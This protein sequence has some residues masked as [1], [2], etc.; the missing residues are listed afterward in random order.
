VNS[1]LEVRRMRAEGREVAGT[2]IAWPG[3]PSRV[4]SSSTVETVEMDHEAQEDG[5]HGD[6]GKAE[7]QQQQQ[8]QES[9]LS[10]QALN[11]QDQGQKL[12]PF[13]Q[14]PA[15]SGSASPLYDHQQKHGSAQQIS[16]QQYDFSQHQQG[17]EQQQQ[18]QQDQSQA[19]SLDGTNA[20]HWNMLP[21]YSAAVRSLNMS[22]PNGFDA[23]PFFKYMA[24]AGL[25][26]PSKFAENSNQAL[27]ALQLQF[28]SLKAQ[29]QLHQ[30]ALKLQQLQ[31]HGDEDYSE[32]KTKVTKKRAKRADPDGKGGSV[33][34]RKKSDSCT[35]KHRGVTW[36]R[37]DKRW[38]ARAWIQGKINN[39]GSYPT[40][41]EA[42]IVVDEKYIEI[43]GPEAALILKDG[44]TRETALPELLEQE[45][46]QGPRHLKQRETEEEQNETS[47]S[48]QQHLSLS[49]PLVAHQQQL[50]QAP[51][52]KPPQ[53]TVDAPEGEGPGHAGNTESQQ[54]SSGGQ[55]SKNGN[56]AGLSALQSREEDAA[57]T[58]SAVHHFKFPPEQF[59]PLMSQYPGNNNGSNSSSNNSNQE[60]E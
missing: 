22:L 56:L 6:D 32:E 21:G 39:L 27:Q 16:S 34:K 23:G 51:E 2:V 7:E 46:N 47:E 37:R 3:E 18:Q 20:A 35:S 30:H 49:S 57:Q 45:P 8:H 54:S 17:G 31:Q 10:P 12:F 55:G 29:Q 33:R 53:L 38:I 42:A 40:E 26:D 60:Q 52:Q 5:N 14:F 25:L 41:R 59:S 9:Q 11:F 4:S 24:D 36:H 28:Q 43:Y 15:G 48:Q 13:G 50:L 19:Q 44:I 1:G 58:L